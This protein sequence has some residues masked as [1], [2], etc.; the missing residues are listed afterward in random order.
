MQAV[1]VQAA[2]IA[3]TGLQ[4][5]DQIPAT[6]GLQGAIH[7]TLIRPLMDKHF[8]GTLHVLV[9]GQVCFQRQLVTTT[10]AISCKK[11]HH[12]TLWEICLLIYNIISVC[13]LNGESN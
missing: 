11:Y 1:L 13:P 12:G 10:L 7:T 3:I 6:F 2:T 4:I 9:K 5:V 8:F